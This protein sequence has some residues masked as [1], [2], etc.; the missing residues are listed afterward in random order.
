MRIERLR[1][2]DKQLLSGNAEDTTGKSALRIRAGT[3]VAFALF[4]SPTVNDCTN[5]D[6]SSLDLR[7]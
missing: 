3:R 4:M 5:S 1:G 6:M 7:S 2:T